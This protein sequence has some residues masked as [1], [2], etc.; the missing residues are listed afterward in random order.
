MRLNRSTI[1]LLLVSL[2]VIV[3]IVLFNNSQSAQEAGTPTPSSAN[4]G[5]VF[6]NV[7]ADAVN[8][9][10]VI[11]NLS[12]ATTVMTKDEG[13][14]WEIAEA[15]NSTD[16]AVDQDAVTTGL[17]DFVSLESADSFESD[18]LADFGLDQPSRSILVTT[19]DGSVYTLHIGDTNP[20]GD[21][22]YALIEVE[23]GSGAAPVD[24]AATTEAANEIQ[25]DETVAVTAETTE[26]PQA[27][28]D[29]AEEAKTEE[30]ASKPAHIIQTTRTP[31]PTEEADEAETEEA[32]T[33]A[34]TEEAETE[35]TLTEEAATE[36]VTEAAAEEIVTE[37]P[38]ATAEATEELPAL[39][40]E[41]PS[42]TPTFTPTP[43]VTISGS[44]TVYLLPKRVVDG[45]LN[46]IDTPPYVPAPTDTPTP[47]PTANPYSEVEQTATAGV[48]LT[49]TQQAFEAIMTQ[50]AEEVTP[51]ITE[52]AN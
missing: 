25:A 19:N 7:S 1:I 17:A 21:R 35:E 6:E 42:P 40:T 11:D 18:S 12:G 52:A 15:T 51:E 41:G 24:E 13:G 34:V 39:P 32:A 2:V 8:H 20:N 30:G 37:E 49:A 10:E 44:G 43:R 4:A 23:Q 45:V 9:I 50:M 29:A 16:R 26:E 27:A 14:A 3:G 46:Y 5:P 47:F 28:E 22:Y 36:A 31:A 48:E 33:E 38:E